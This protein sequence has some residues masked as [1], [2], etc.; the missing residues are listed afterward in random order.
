[1][2]TDMEDA[3]HEGFRAGA[4]W[5]GQ[6]CPY[7]PGSPQSAAWLTGRRQGLLQQRGREP[8]RGLDL[9]IQLPGP[10]RMTSLGASAAAVGQ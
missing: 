3:W 8:V 10:A 9:G 5:P 7:S 1:M 6:R 4:Y 2:S